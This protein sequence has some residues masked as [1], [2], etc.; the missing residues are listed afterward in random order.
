MVLGGAGM[1][2]HKTFQLLQRRFTGAF[3]TVREDMREPPFDRV[4]LLQ[5]DLSSRAS[6]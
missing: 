1:L 6:M 4:E 2:G 5:G 3:C